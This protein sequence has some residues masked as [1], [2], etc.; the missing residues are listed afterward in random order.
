MKTKNE[1]GDWEK[2]VAKLVDGVGFT[3][4]T[5]QDATLVCTGV[6][7]KRCP[8]V[9]SKGQIKAIRIGDRYGK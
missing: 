4:A 7:E 5:R 9:V 6:N 2:V 8:R 1:L 3:E